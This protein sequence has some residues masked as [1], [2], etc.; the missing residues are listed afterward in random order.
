MIDI[1]HRVGVKAPISKVYAAISTIEGVAGWWTKETTGVSKPGGT[2][3]FE[4][5]TPSGEKI[6]G[7]GMEVKTLDPDKAVYWRVKTGPEEWI[8]TDVTFD[9]TQDGEYTIV[10]FGHMNWREAVEF[11]AHCST[12]WATFLLSLRDLVET[13]KGR[14]APNDVQI[15]NWH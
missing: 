1:I 5:S 2:I 10:R 8:G 7:F 12:K 11:T 3:E 4:F 9:L 13:G 15:G 14:P 6:G